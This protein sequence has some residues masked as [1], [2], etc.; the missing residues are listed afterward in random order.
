MGDLNT[1]NPLSDIQRHFSPREIS[2]STP[3]I[4]KG[5]ESG[6][7]LLNPP[8]EYTRFARVVKARP[9]FIDLAFANPPLLALVKSSE[10]SLHSKGSDHIPITITLAAPSLNQEPPRPQL[11]DTDWETLDP[12]IKGFKVPA[13]P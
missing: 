2:S 8:G 1:H 11:A 3:Y 7:G 4:E 5:A 9:S 6:F 10:A 12:I 13:A